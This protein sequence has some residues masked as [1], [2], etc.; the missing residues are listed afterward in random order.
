MAVG[1]KVGAE[2]TLLGDGS[3]VSAFFATIAANLEPDGWGSRFPTVM[4]PLYEGDL[5][6]ED[7]SKA[8]EE[9]HQIRAEL[10]KLAP[11]RVVW[12]YDDRAA[13]P[14]W[15]D[16]IAD[17]ITDLGNYFVTMDGKDTFDVLDEALEYADES[18][19][20]ATV[21]SVGPV[22]AGPDSS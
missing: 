17:D 20:G 15:G 22:G 14:P 12:D 8:R 6:P 21:K 13:R 7:V 10:S 9:L 5:P 11:D 4:G 2:V 18:D 16:D 3:F 19:Q 1:I